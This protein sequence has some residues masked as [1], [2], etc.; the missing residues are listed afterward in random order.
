MA[1]SP[2]AESGYC[3]VM[4]LEDKFGIYRRHVKTNSYLGQIEKAA[5][6]ASEDGTGSYRFPCPGD[7]PMTF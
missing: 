2:H 6:R 5:G 3:V 7:G 4:A 1:P